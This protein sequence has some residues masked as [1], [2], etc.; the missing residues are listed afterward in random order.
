MSESSLSFGYSLGKTISF[1]PGG[2]S[3]GAILPQ[4]PRPDIKTAYAT[5][6][7]PCK[8][9]EPFSF[10]WFKKL[11][12]IFISIL[13]LVLGY[14]FFPKRATVNIDVISLESGNPIALQTL[15]KK[16]A[17]KPLFINFW[18]TWC[19]VCRN[20]IDAISTLA[21]KHA[22]IIFISTDQDMQTAQN[23]LSRKKHTDLNMYSDPKNEAMNFFKIKGLPTTVKVGKNCQVIDSHIG[24]LNASTIALFF[25]VPLRDI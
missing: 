21:R 10:M 25:D 14:A 18:A 9:R 3:R 7:I 5:N 24:P 6:L 11:I 12:F 8:N 15:C 4:P 2:G 20:D 19:P 17:S 16:A 13:C 22:N 23:F 1:P